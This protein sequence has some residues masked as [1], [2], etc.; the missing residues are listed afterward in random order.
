MTNIIV[1]CGKSKTSYPAPAHQLYTGPY[2]RLAIGCAKRWASLDDIYIFSAKYG[3][4]HSSTILEPYEQTLSMPGAIGLS[5]VAEQ[6]RQ[7]DGDEVC[8]LGGSAY[9]KMLQKIRQDVKAPL[10]EVDG[11]GMGK[12][13]ALMRFWMYGY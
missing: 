4:I 10:Q 9:L 11:L 5:T 2:Y 6:L 1:A 13:M 3:V 12:Q 7:L 8:F